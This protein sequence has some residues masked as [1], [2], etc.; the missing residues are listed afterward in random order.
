[1]GDVRS[2]SGRWHAEKEE[3]VK[4]EK[5]GGRT[6]AW[7]LSNRILR[8]QLLEAGMEAHLSV[9]PRIHSYIVR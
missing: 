8:R 5:M 1:M 7:L 6:M 4:R 9:E 3:N 2:G